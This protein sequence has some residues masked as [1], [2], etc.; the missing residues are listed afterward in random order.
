MDTD[1]ELD[2]DVRMEERNYA[3]PRRTG[4]DGMPLHDADSAPPRDED[5]G[6]GYGRDPLPSPI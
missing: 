3:R 2:V 6:G 4:Y 1:T 5:L